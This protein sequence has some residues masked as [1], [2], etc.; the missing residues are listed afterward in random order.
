MESNG[1]KNEEVGETEREVGGARSVTEAGG[2]CGGGAGACEDR[3]S[4]GDYGD[5]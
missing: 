1:R 3:C 4:A 5:R 2:G